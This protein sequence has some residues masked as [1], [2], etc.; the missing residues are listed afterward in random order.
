MVM[1][2]SCRRK[3]ET[4]T[5]VCQAVQDQYILWERIAACGFGLVVLEAFYMHISDKG[6]KKKSF[7][8]KVLSYVNEIAKYLINADSYGSR[9][10]GFWMRFNVFRVKCICW[11]Y[12]FPLRRSAC[13]TKVSNIDKKYHVALFKVCWYAEVSILLRV[14]VSLMSQFLR[15]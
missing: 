8:K 12:H 9:M 2:M 6:G 3:A 4:I 7:F 10:D 13:Q 11:T 14:R 15:H 5:G 1:L